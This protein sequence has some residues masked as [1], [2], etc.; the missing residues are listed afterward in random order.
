[1]DVDSETRAKRRLAWASLGCGVG[2]LGLGLVVVSGFF[3]GPGQCGEWGFGCVEAAWW[4]LA[5]GLALGTAVAAWSFAG[6]GKASWLN[7]VA[8]LA[9][10]LPALAMA[11][12]MAMVIGR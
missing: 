3:A 2:G 12:F 9:S 11:I 4:S 10:G 7:V 6:P 1:M 5:L 8:L